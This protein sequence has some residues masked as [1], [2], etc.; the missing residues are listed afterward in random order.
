MQKK[1]RFANLYIRY[2]VK[3]PWLFY[4]YLGTFICIFVL[5][6]CRLW[7]EERKCYEGEIQGCEIRIRQEEKPELLGDRIYLYTD[8]NREVLPFLVKQTQ[9]RDGVLH[10][11]LCEEQK[12][13]H[14]RVTV[15]T[16]SA[17]CTLLQK[18]FAKAGR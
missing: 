18:V 5:T 10:I 13:F 8:K 6:G 17:K 15:E 1:Q 4:G 12:Q 14:G 7:L 3:S 2:V 9:Y 16:V 11:I